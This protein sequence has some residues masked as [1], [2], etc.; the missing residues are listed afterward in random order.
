M[1]PASGRVPVTAPALPAPVTARLRATR[2]RTGSRLTPATRT[3]P[4]SRGRLVISH[5]TCP[6][7]LAILVGVLAGH[8]GSPRIGGGSPDQPVPAPAARLTLAVGTVRV[9]SRATAR[10]DRG[11]IARAYRPSRHQWA[12]PGTRS[13]LTPTGR[14]SG[15]QPGGFSPNR[16]SVNPI[17][18]SWLA[19]S[20]LFSLVRTRTPVL[21]GIFASRWSTR[22]QGHHPWGQ[23]WPGTCSTPWSR[24]PW[25]QAPGSGR[26]RASRPAPAGG[27]LTSSQ[28]EG[29]A[30]AIP[31]SA[32]GALE[33][34]HPRAERPRGDV[35]PTG[36][37]G[38]E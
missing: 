27:R 33:T 21:L 14:Q 36:A 3:A 31:A 26:C 32:S 22:S 18:R 29:H 34:T 13:A 25:G 19:A 37:L 5:G 8:Q 16:V 9:I 2:S 12:R 15:T 1:A 20:P 4:F 24:P 30:W 11:S 6:C 38:C 17:Q 35:S 23:P 7:P 28:V 10:S